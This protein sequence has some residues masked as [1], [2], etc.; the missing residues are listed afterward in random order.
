MQLKAFF[1]VVAST[2][3]I[4]LATPVQASTFTAKVA[5]VI[6]GDTIT[7]MHNGAREKVIFYGIDCPELGQK[8]GPEA[9]QFTDNSCF[10]KD[11]TIEEHGQDPNGRTIAVITLADGTN[12]NQE[13]LKQG[14]AWWSDKYAPKETQLKQCKERIVV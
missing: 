1:F 12:L 6:D 10:H 13:L 8:F 4:S 11:V 14:L 9:K 7:I 3:A 5:S 2:L